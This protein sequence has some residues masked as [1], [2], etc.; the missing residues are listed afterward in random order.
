MIFRNSHQ[1]LLPLPLLLRGP[2]PLATRP[3][4]R[5]GQ[6]PLQRRVV[7]LVNGHDMIQVLQVAVRVAHEVRDSGPRERRQLPQ[8]L[9]VLIGHL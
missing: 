1:Q 2:G 6:Q 5:S 3:E 4:G 8:P 7:Q 9:H